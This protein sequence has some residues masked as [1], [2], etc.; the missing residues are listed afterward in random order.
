[1]LWIAGVMAAAQTFR[2]RV[3]VELDRVELLAT[4]GRGRFV[5]GLRPSEIRVTVDGRPVSVESFE[6]PSLLP[7]LPTAPP[8]PAPTLDAAARRP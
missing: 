3:N 4:D 7:D 1:L 2:E 6:A 5:A 8:R